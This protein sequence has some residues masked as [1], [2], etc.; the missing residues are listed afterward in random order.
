MDEQDIKDMM[1]QLG[2]MTALANADLPARIF[3][4]WSTAL[5]HLAE[6]AAHT[7]ENS[8][9]HEVGRLLEPGLARMFKLMDFCIERMEMVA[10]T[11]PKP[12]SESEPQP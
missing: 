2:G 9:T 7:L 8:T 4:T 11:Q 1:G 6:A 5:K 12:R 10:A 3:A